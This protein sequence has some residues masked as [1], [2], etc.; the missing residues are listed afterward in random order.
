VSQRIGVAVETGAKKVFATAVDWPG[1]SRSGR[2]EE[3]ALAALAA[4]A[5]RYAAVAKEAGEAFPPPPAGLEDLDIVER[6]SGG[7]ST[8]FGVPSVVTDLDRRPVSAVEADRLC[9]LVG[10][11]WTVF[12]RVAANAPKEL[13]TGPRGGGRDRDKIVDHVLG[14]DHVYAREMGA[15]AWPPRRAPIAAR[16]RRCARSCSISSASRRTGPRSAGA[17]GRHATPPAGSPGTPSI[18]LG[19]SRTV[20]NPIEGE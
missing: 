8:D 4:A 16:S 15:S 1:W 12:D 10:A 17:S 20:A 6:N 3:L 18:T 2:T 11:A 5:E 9:R 14:A 13:R 7:A 19:R